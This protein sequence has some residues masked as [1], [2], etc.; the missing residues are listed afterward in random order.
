MIDRETSGREASPTGGVINSQTVK[1][2]HAEERGYDSGK[3][4]VGRKRHT[5]VGAGGCP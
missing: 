4:I 5:A 1:A 2:P 3:K